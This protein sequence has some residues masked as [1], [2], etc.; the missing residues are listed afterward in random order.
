MGI[1]DKLISR[2]EARTR[3]LVSYFTGVLCKNDHL[4]KRYTHT[5]ICY[6][7]KRARAS[8]WYKN[9][10][11]IVKQIN[12][13]SRAKNPDRV[14][15]TQNRW[16]ENNKEKLRKIKRRNKKK[17][18]DKYLEADKIR[19]KKRR[20][21]DPFWRA[22]K[23]MS[24]AIWAALKKLKAGRHWEDVIGYALKDLTEH[25]ERQF[26]LGM[27]WENYGPYW[28]IDHIRPVSWFI[29]EAKGSSLDIEKWIIKAFALKNLQPLLAV[30]N[31]SKNNFYEGPYQSK[32]S[33]R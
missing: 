13:R 24:K 2:E 27:T 8:R 19:Q 9:S 14:K 25:L 23:N 32:R 3:G 1:I 17:H 29:H 4:D 30:H 6:A 28:H 7:C 31:L 22:S 5:G 20:A 18:R 26:N 12:D 11:Q 16:N 15:A 10:P 21:S 33:N